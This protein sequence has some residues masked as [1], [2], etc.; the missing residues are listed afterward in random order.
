MGQK[1][2]KDETGIDFFLEKKSTIWF[3]IMLAAV[4]PG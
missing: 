2:L 4:S 3:N 1:L